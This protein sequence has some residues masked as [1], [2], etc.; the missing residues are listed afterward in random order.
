MT[1]QKKLQFMH[2]NP[3]TSWHEHM[4]GTGAGLR[5]MVPEL[6]ENVVQTMDTLGIDKI[7]TCLPVS[8]DSK[9][10]PEDFARA[11]NYTYDCIKRYPKRV[12]GM[13]FVNPGF[14]D[15]ML[16]EVDRCVNE[17]GFVGVKLMHQYFMDDPAM[18]PL[19]EKCIDLDIP[20]YMH[21]AHLMDPLSRSKQPRCSDGVHMANIARRY[22][23]GTFIMGHLG[24]GGD[25][26]W[27]LR[28]IADTPNVFTDIG[29]SICD[30]PLVEESVK[31]L[32]AD[33]I[34]FATDGS[35]S[36]T[37]GKLLGADISDD[38]KK[39]ILAGTA[40]QR[41]LTRTRK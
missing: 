33:R 18:Y 38:E 35:W 27:S 41:Y 20:I 21:T 1:I 15:A 23:E 22:P 34:L 28:A 25:W 19:V 36:S 8:Y 3:V 6:V 4:F 11:N 14:R 17:L 24:G 32:G 16:D 29:G 30:R 26:Q 2:N 31:H 9:V 37:V 10:G 12:Y 7:V 40:F 5:G 39:T 13:C